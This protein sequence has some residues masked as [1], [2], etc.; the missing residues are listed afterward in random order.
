MAI[1]S[2]YGGGL[3]L[4]R[5]NAGP[6]YVWVEPGDVDQAAKRMSVDRAVSSLITGD[7]VAIFK[8]DSNGVVKGGPLP[9]MAAGA[10]EDG[11]RWS[12][13]QW[14]VHVDAIGGIRFYSSWAKALKGGIDDAA[15]LLSVSSRCRIRINLVSGDQ[16]CLAQTEAWDL[17][18]NREIADITPLGE[19]FQKNMATLVSGF[20]SLDCLFSAGVDECESIIE[21]E[22]SIYLHRL[23]LRQEVGA[24]FIGVFLLKRVGHVVKDLDDDYDQQEL[25]YLCNCVITNVAS[26]VDVNSII[27]SR[28]EFVTTDEIKLLYDY[29]KVYLAQEGLDAD[30]VL[31]ENDSGI[32]VDLPI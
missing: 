4:Q 28:I 6:A 15:P 3:K 9:F 7:Y 26:T 29:P 23:A 32:L 1:W 16:K 18:T 31:Q 25:F 19:A 2:G 11:T 17:N 27:H 24:E 22:K 21:H 12:D 5:A 20:G 8:V 30:K 10:W 14:Y 13:G